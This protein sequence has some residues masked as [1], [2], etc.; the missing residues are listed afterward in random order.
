MFDLNALRPAWTPLTIIL[1]VIGFIVYWPIGLGVLAYILAGD[2]IP[3]VK[4]FFADAPGKKDWWPAWRG[5]SKG[6]S[7]TGNV[8]FDEYREKEMK[9]MEEERSKLD[10]E[11]RAFETFMNDVHAARDREE[12]D[13]FTR[14]AS[15]NRGTAKAT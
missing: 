1:M 7:R 2:R 12:F 10:E 3:E 14:E 9:R 11:R 8:A 13:R 4:K 5:G 15:A 6:Y